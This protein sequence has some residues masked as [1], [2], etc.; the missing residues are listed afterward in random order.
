MT[1]TISRR[2][3][4]YRRSCLSQ[5][6]KFHKVRYFSV[7]SRSDCPTAHIAKKYVVVRWE[8]VGNWLDHNWIPI[9]LCHVFQHRN[10]PTD[11]SPINGKK[12]GNGCS[13]MITNIIWHVPCAFSIPT[14]VLTNHQ[15]WK[16]KN[17]FVTGC[18]NFQLSTVVDHEN[19]KRHK[20]SCAKQTAE[21]NLPK[22][23]AYN[24]LLS[25]NEHKRKQLEYKFRNIHAV[26]CL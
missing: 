26:R 10:F 3:R 22:N 11:T 15:I 14:L 8:I 20:D 4:E 16:T 24:S 17:L 9:F 13:I 5:P 12:T 21:Q 19:S 18:K 6:P 1:K 7:L 25:L 23:P 2:V